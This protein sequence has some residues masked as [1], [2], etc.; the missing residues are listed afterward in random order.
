M[1]HHNYNTSLIRPLPM[2]ISYII[3]SISACECEF[4]N[5]LSIFFGRG[6][7]DGC[8]LLIFN[9]RYLLCCVY[10]LVVWFIVKNH[11]VISIRCKNMRRP[12]PPRCCA[13]ENRSIYIR[14]MAMMW[15]YFGHLAF[16]EAKKVFA[17]WV[18]GAGGGG[19]RSFSFALSFK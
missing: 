15:R 17:M 19:V 5:F 1:F 16:K 10:F 14:L 13:G 2:R 18:C 12:C 3:F 11:D 4:V 8:L 6:Y 9:D 7:I